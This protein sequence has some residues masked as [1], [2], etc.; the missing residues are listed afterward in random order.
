MK[1]LSNPQRSREKIDAPED[2]GSPERIERARTKCGHITSNT[3]ALL[4]FLDVEE[5]RD[6]VSYSSVEEMDREL[7]RE[8]Q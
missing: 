1:T 3:D 6:L 2:R 7:M 5:D 4:A 8:L